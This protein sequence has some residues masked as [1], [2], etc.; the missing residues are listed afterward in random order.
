MSVASNASLGSLGLLSAYCS[1]EDFVAPVLDTTTEILFD[2]LIDLNS[3][4]I[5]CRECGEDSINCRSRLCSSLSP[6]SKGFQMF[7]KNSHCGHRKHEKSDDSELLPLV[8]GQTI[9]FYSFAEVLNGEKEGEEF[10]TFS[11]GEYLS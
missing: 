1:T 8:E 7:R 5:V 3:V 4:T 11:V 10:Q 6:C 9:N 2:P